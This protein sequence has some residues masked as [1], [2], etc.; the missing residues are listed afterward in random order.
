MPVR[1]FTNPYTFFPPTDAAGAIS[2][3]EAEAALL[4]DESKPSASELR[5][6]RYT[7]GTHTGRITC[8]L[9][10]QTACVFG[11]THASLGTDSFNVVEN[12]K[13]NNEIAIPA[14]SLRGMISSIAEA[15]SGSAMRVLSNRQLSIRSQIKQSRSAIGMVY[16]H[17]GK[18]WILPLTFPNLRKKQQVFA[19]MDGSTVEQ[20]Q[21]IDN[22]LFE[23]SGENAFLMFPVYTALKPRIEGTEVDSF[24]SGNRS[25]YAVRLSDLG[26]CDPVWVSIYEGRFEISG[27]EVR[28]GSIIRPAKFLKGNIPL[29]TWAKS[30]KY[31]PGIL[32]ILPHN[33]AANAGTKRYNL[34]IPVAP[35]WV[36]EGQFTP[37]PVGLLEASLAIERFES[38]VADKTSTIHNN[39]RDDSCTLLRGQGPQFSGLQHGD[40]VHFRLER[41]SSAA[42]IP[43]VES[44]SISSVWREGPTFL[45]NATPQQKRVSTSPDIITNEQRPFHAARKTVSI[46]ER[47]FG[48]VEQEEKK[49]G[50][51][52][53]TSNS[54]RAYKGRVRFSNGVL[55]ANQEVPLMC[56]KD[57]EWLRFCN[58]AAATKFSQYFP[59]QIL[60]SPKVPCPEVYFQV[61]GKPIDFRR[62]F[63]DSR[64]KKISGR[65]FYWS[66]AS[67][68][69][70]GRV[71]GTTSD[72]QGNNANQDQKA[73]VRPIRPGVS[74]TF[75]VDFENLTDSELDLLCFSL[76]PSDGFLHKLGFAKPLGLGSVQLEVTSSR[77]SD[78]R[79][80]FRSSLNL[81]EKPGDP[82]N[83]SKESTFD[84]LSRSRRWA[85]DYSQVA[86]RFEKLGT[87]VAGPVVYPQA[88]AT[89]SELEHFRWFTANRDD[90]YRVGPAQSLPHLDSDSSMQS[91]ELR[92]RRYR[93]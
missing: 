12:F 25:A 45:W 65:K 10:T 87:P 24:H 36:K 39:E 63:F 79:K 44:V 75:S 70:G 91:V 61:T 88:E 84:V 55:T 29:H 47:M 46:A 57:P 20:W 78:K 48:W 16:E 22:K 66:H 67:A 76:L 73:M 80:K 42:R 89:F 11:G 26:D 32:R 2:R 56:N 3:L 71:P 4:S 43:A 69:G 1:K 49:G 74:F 40:L 52:V 8:R 17:Q 38:T 35:R 30:E 13:L 18:R 53:E 86:Q 9:T 64:I 77:D 58:N 34:F 5:H 82:N 85:S 50:D 68:I 60:A 31:V 93:R 90:D 33:P 21:L 28:R 83:R 72:F 92:P 19:P 81:I 59:L 54:L 14:T 41:S 51:A 7:E 23:E 27:E 6:D 62:A 37:P 15:A